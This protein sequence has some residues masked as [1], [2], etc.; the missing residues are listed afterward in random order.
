M[1]RKLKGI[2]V[3]RLRKFEDAYFAAANFTKK[4]MDSGL[5]VQVDSRFLY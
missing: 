4:I 2:M 5:P 3:E 1:T